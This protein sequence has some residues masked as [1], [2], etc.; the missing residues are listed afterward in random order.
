MKESVLQGRTKLLSKLNI[1][2]RDGNNE[3]EEF[4]RLFKFRERKKK[5]LFVRKGKKKEL[6]WELFGK[7]ILKSR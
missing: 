6:V 1:L 7:K 3:N 4:T 5:S 2:P